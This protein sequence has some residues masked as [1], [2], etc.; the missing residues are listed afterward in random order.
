MSPSRCERLGVAGDQWFAAGIG[1]G[2]D[3]HEVAGVVQPAGAGR[4]AGA[5]VEQQVVQR[6]VRQHDAQHR[7]PR[8]DAAR[9]V[10]RGIAPR[11]QHDG[12]LGRL[13]D[14]ALA[15]VQRRQAR[16]GGGVGDHQ[17]KRFLLALL[18]QAQ[19]RDGFRPGRVANQV[20]TAEALDGQ[21]GALPQARERAADRVR[22]RLA[23]APRIEQRQRRTAVGAGVRLGVEAAM[24]HV[25][26]LALARAAHREGGHAGV[27]P[28]VRQRTRDRVARAA[29]RAV[30]ERIAP[31][32]IPG[33]EQFR[34]TVRTDGGVRGDV[35]AVAAA[36]A[37]DDRER[38]RFIARRARAAFHLR[39]PRQ[40]RRFRGE[41]AL[42]LVEP[43]G[44]ALDL[45]VHTLA[46]VAHE[47]AERQP[48]GD[49]EHE[50][51]EADALHLSAHPQ[52]AALGNA[53]DPGRAVHGQLPPGGAATAP[54]RASIHASQR[55]SPAPVVAETCSSGSPGLTRSA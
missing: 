11:Q 28:V 42:E 16:R 30:D 33:I 37:G 7:Q 35:R 17:R 26:V 27:A 53:V 43:V 21:D 9:L 24:L 49:A 52:P 22:V 14:F 31:A 19:P 47:A 4:P 1:G 54:A 25:V 13:E 6:R 50:G 51:P 36:V 20:K 29:V 12:P 18:A 46:V 2:A 32:T 15:G 8:R 48:G 41:A 45:D 44:R 38:H 5:L 34:E 10:G 55:S 39:D 40:P 3:E 23:Q